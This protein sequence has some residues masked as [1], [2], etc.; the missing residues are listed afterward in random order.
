[1]EINWLT[2]FAQIINFLILVAVL[3]RFLYGPIVRAM[4]RREQK[5]SDRIQAAEKQREAAQAEAE[6]YRQMQQ[7]FAAE[8]EA[9]FSQLKA[10]VEQTRKAL[11]Q[12]MREEVDNTSRRWQDGIKRQQDGF[13]LELRH[14]ASVQVQSAIRRALI[15][16]AN[17]DLEQQMIEVF[18]ERIE[19]LNECALASLDRNSNPIVV[20]SSFDIPDEA[21]PKIIQAV[22]DKVPSHINLEFETEPELI[23]GIEL[24]ASGYKLAWSVENYLDRLE[25]SLSAV[26]EE[27]TGIA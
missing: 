22:R 8:R 20:C 10:E 1:M 23:C 25:E 4:D 24:R 6:Q 2:F 15:D 11:M 12:N 18:I 26:F 17:V 27:E 7:E 19:K 21:R 14:R 5:I 9:M 13:M 16:L 3:Q